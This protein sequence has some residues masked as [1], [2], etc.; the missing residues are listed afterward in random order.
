MP[1]MEV[2]SFYF[3]DGCKLEDTPTLMNFMY[4]RARA[5]EKSGNYRRA[6]RLFPIFLES[7]CRRSYEG[8]SADG[9]SASSWAD[10]H[11]APEVGYAGYRGDAGGYE[12]VEGL[13]TG[14]LGCDAGGGRGD[15]QGRRSC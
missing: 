15:L 11:G 14:T 8:F 5:A 6:L 3:L 7:V 10:L 1:K 9:R 4:W 13:G 12:M 2:V